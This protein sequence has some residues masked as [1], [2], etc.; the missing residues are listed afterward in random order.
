MAFTGLPL[1]I[2]QIPKQSV[3]ENAVELEFVGLPGQGG[4]TRPYVPTRPGTPDEDGVVWHP[5]SRTNDNTHRTGSSR[6]MPGSIAEEHGKMGELVS[7]W[8]T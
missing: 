3:Q 6:I 7:L 1:S 4:R 5:L 8:P 2:V